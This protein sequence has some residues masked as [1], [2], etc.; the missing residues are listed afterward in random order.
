MIRGGKIAE[1]VTG[2]G[3]TLVATL[4]AYLNGLLPSEEWKQR[5]QREPWYPGDT[6]S[7]A[8][9][10]GLLAVTPVRQ[11]TGLSRMPPWRTESLRRMG[12]RR[13]RRGSLVTCRPGLTRQ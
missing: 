9:G 6:I 3:K 10:Q 4:P 13:M 12:S 2:E 5:T 1:M 8:I 11:R 7:V